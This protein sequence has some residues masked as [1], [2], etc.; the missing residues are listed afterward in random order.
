MIKPGYLPSY[1]NTKENFPKALE[2]A[3]IWSPILQY[4]SDYIEPKLIVLMG[5]T[6]VAPLFDPLKLSTSNAR[7]ETIMH[8]ASVDRIKV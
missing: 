8:Y 1:L 2:I 6:I 3:K 4:E 5:K 7:I